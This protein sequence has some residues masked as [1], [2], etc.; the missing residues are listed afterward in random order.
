M[1]K[2]RGAGAM[3]LG[4][5][6][7]GPG[8]ASVQF[9][10]ADTPADNASTR[11]AWLAAA[12]V[13]APDYLEDFES[14][15]LLNTNVSGVSGVL[16]GGLVVTDTSSDAE[17][18]VR[19]SSTYFGGSNPVG[20]QSLAHNE[21]QYLQ[22]DFGSG[23]VDYVGGLGLDHGA[24][25]IIVTY[26]GGATSTHSLE[27]TG[28]SGDTAEFWGFYK[29]D[30]PRITRLQLD[31]T[32]DGEWGIDNIEFSASPVPEPGTVALVG[33]ALA[34]AARRRARRS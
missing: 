13:A 32:G 3:A 4:L 5:A 34:A 20:G 29:N 23:G 12:G 19:N 17:A 11:A 27:L 31:A 8:F 9:F 15:A 1:T 16:A 28:S 10:N 7:A 6:L 2:T 21:H 33:L 18:Y 24:T 30:M 14:G 22:L 26:V 25:T